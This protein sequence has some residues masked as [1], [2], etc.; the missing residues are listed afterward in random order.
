M[1]FLM[2]VIAICV[3]SFTVAY[4]YRIKERR[5][6][7]TDHGVLRQAYDMRR[8]ELEHEARVLA[9]PQHERVE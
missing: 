5:L 9:L 4:C 2:F 3:P 8:L 7:R 6:E 1:E